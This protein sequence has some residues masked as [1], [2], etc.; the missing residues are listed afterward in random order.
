MQKT[1]EKAQPEWVEI[2]TSFISEIQIFKFSKIKEI[3]KCYK[4]KPQRQILQIR[5][6]Y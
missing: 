2:V 6:T 3:S 4:T 1:H 5:K